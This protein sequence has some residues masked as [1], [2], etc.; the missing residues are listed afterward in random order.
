M[1]HL[2]TKIY[3]TTESVKFLSKRVVFLKISNSIFIISYAFTIFQNENTTYNDKLII[4]IHKLLKNT[5]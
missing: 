5:S 3:L 1:S 4:F 2:K